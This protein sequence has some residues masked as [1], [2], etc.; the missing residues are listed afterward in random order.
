MAYGD[1]TYEK[2]WIALLQEAADHV[3]RKI[4]ITSWSYAWCGHI[5]QYDPARTTDAVDLV[6][7]ERQR[8]I[9]VPVLLAYDEMFQGGVIR[10]GVENV[11]ERT[12][13]VTYKPDALLPDAN[14]I[15]WIIRSVA[16]QTAL[17]DRAGNINGERR[18]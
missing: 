7:K 2:E 13:R 11:K 14:L 17:P 5:A 1:L 4:G 12:L 6:L 16:T 3:R 9:V 18:K 15:R 8:A 10:N